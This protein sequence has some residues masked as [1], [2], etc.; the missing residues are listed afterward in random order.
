MAKTNANTPHKT[1]IN[2]QIHLKVHFF[3][4]VEFRPQL[5]FDIINLLLAACYTCMLALA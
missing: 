5:Q 3:V 1:I 2:L 4:N